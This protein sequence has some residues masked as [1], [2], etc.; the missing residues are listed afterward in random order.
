VGATLRDPDVR[1]GLGL[2]ILLFAARGV[3]ELVRKKLYRV[4]VILLLW[5]SYLAVYPFLVFQ[6]TH[7]LLPFYVVF[8]LTSVGVTAS[9]SNVSGN[10]EHYFWYITLIGLI[11]IGI[12]RAYLSLFPA[13][14]LV[15]V[16]LVIVWSILNY[17]EN[18]PV[19][20]CIRLMVI[21]M[22][23]LMSGHYSQPKLL[24]LNDGSEL[25]ATLFLREHLNPASFVGAYA[26]KNVWMAKQNYIPM[27][28]N[29]LPALLTDG[30]F[31]AWLKDNQLHAIYSDPNLKILEPAIWQLVQKHVGKELQV[32]FSSQDGRWQVVTTRNVSD[33]DPSTFIDRPW[34]SAKPRFATEA[35]NKSTGNVFT[36]ST[37]GGP[38]ITFISLVLASFLGGILALVGA[39]ALLVLLVHVEMEDEAVEKHRAKQTLS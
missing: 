5:S 38:M 19:L 36:D 23:L 15:L 8:L 30:E 4:V 12:A 14:P 39:V 33:A 10:R 24:S 6:P 2:I 17:Q 21:L 11:V 26:P 16:S 9:V 3:I 22:A 27:G 28:R 29:A 37:R 25:N 35:H 31:S 20:R 34:Y 7:F 32:G 13:L 18:D 1:R